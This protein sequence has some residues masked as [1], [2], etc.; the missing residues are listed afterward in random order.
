MGL[1]PLSGK[2][3]EITAI[4]GVSGPPR[5]IGGSMRSARWQSIADLPIVAHHRLRHHSATAK[6]ES[7]STATREFMSVA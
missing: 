2:L 6:Q 7:S 4:E 5:N 3:I 1:S